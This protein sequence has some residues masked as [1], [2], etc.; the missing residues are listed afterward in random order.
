MRFL[1]AGAIPLGSGNDFDSSYL[2]P[3]SRNVNG[4]LLPFSRS[5]L[6][7]RRGRYFARTRI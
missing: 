2:N 1:I 4:R 3:A 5:S 7:Y 6:Q